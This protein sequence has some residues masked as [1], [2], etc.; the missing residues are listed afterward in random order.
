ML[1]RLSYPGVQDST[2]RALSFA[3]YS[4]FAYSALNHAQISL[5]IGFCVNSF[6]GNLYMVANKGKGLLQ[7]M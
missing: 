6:S 1:Y 7:G 5:D 4:P 2:L 3:I